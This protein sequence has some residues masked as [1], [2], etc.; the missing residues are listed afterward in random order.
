MQDFIVQNFSKLYC[1]CGNYSKQFKRS[2]EI[3]G[4]KASSS[5]LLVGINS[6]Y[7]NYTSISGY[8]SSVTDICVEY[9]GNS[10]SDEPSKKG[11]R[12]SNACKYKEPF[13]NC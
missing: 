3:S 4:I 5:K 13:P 12:P 8:A 10:S 9:T 11:S 1:S 2:I 6:N 7:S